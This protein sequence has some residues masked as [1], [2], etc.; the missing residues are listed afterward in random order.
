MKKKIALV[1]SLVVVGVAVAAPDVDPWV[2]FYHQNRYMVPQRFEAETRIAAVDA[3]SIR[4]L[5]PNFLGGVNTI[6]QL[7]AGSQSRVGGA[8]IASATLHDAGTIGVHCE[9]GTGTCSSGVLTATFAHT[10]SVRPHCV[11][12]SQ[13][14]AGCS[15]EGPASTTA[16]VFHGGSS[17]ILDW[18]CCGTR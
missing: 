15:L 2:T 9:T 13:A 6:A 16:A 8:R 11:C 10:F 18:I 1:L 7:D 4:A 12:I 14:D 17:S 3:G 5:G